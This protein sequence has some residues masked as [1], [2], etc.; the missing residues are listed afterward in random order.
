MQ[1]VTEKWPALSEGIQHVGTGKKGNEDCP[2]ELVNRILNEW[3]AAE[4]PLATRAAFWA[5]LWWK[6]VSE[7][8]K[9]LL[10]LL[11]ENSIVSASDLVQSISPEASQKVKDW[12]AQLLGGKTLTREEAKSIGRFLFGTEPDDGARAIIATILRVRYA[13]ENEYA[14]L[15]EALEETYEIGFREPVPEGKPILQLSEPFDGV[16]RSFLLTPLLMHHWTKKGFRVVGL[17]GRNAGPKWGFNLQ[18]IVEK[19]PEA[20]FLKRNSGLGSLSSPFGWFLKQ[21][22]LS[23]PLDRWVDLR[24]QTIKRPFL[25]TL[26]KYVSPFQA[27]TFIG[28]AFHHNFGE[29]MID[30]AE[31]IGFSKSLVTFKSIEGSLGLSLARSTKIYGSMKMNDGYKRFTV[32]CHPSEFGITVQEDQKNFNPTAT[33]NIQRIISCLATGSSGDAYF[34]DRV[35]YTCAAFD[36]AMSVFE[37]V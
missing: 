14:G 8:E 5:G 20:V 10:K 15:M 30:I 28:S 33:E 24:R 9:N 17:C 27:Q 2:Q 34:D 29:K 4:P 35:R 13:D 11:R 7:T 19:L 25:A 3:N 6:G 23:K 1:L 12:A 16:E 37:E 32:D 21:S 26:E 22:D 18:D 31:A 36:K